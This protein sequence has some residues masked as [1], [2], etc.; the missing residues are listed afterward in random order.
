MNGRMTFLAGIIAGIVS[1]YLL[2]GYSSSLSSPHWMYWNLYLH[3][4][5]S[6]AGFFNHLEGWT[7]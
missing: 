6:V 1:A 4:L 2:I 7:P 5:Y 3:P